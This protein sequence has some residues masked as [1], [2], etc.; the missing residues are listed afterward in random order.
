M[1][2]SNIFEKS[3]LTLKAKIMRGKAAQEDAVWTFRGLPSGEKK[4]PV[5]ISKTAT[6]VTCTVDIEEVPADKDSYMVTYELEADKRKYPGFYAYRVWP[7]SITLKSV[8]KDGKPFPNFPFRVKQGGILPPAKGKGPDTGDK[9]E[10][11]VELKLTGAATIEPLSPFEIDKWNKGDK[12][13]GRAREA[14][15]SRK[16]YTALFYSHPEKDWKQYVNMPPTP[17]PGSNSGSRMK[18][19]VGPKEDK[20]K[21]NGRVG[22][23]GDE[24]F[25]EV[26]FSDKNSKRNDPKPRLI[27][28]GSDVAAEAD[29]RTFKATLK[30]GEGGDPAEFQVEMGFAGGD[31]CTVKAGVTKACEDD[32]VKVTAWRKLLLEVIQPKEECSAYTMSFRTDKKPGLTDNH[33]SL[34]K[35]ELDPVFIE[36]DCSKGV[37]TY[38]KSDLGGKA[39]YLVFDG[40]Y[41]KRDAGKKMVILTNG[42]YGDLRAAKAT[43]NPQSPTSLVTA[44][45]DYYVD[46]AVVNVITELDGTSKTVEL[47]DPKCVFEFDPGKADGTL[48]V[49][50]F[51]WW[52]KQYKNQA[53]QWVNVA[54]PGDPGY[55]KRTAQVATITGADLDQWIHFTHFRKIIV[56]LPKRAGKEATDPGFFL[57]IGGRP[58]RIGVSIKFAGAEI[59][60]LAGGWHG[61]IN[62]STYGGSP[63]SGG[64]VST[65]LH[66]LGHNLGQAYGNQTTDPDYGRTAANAIPGMPFPPGV[67]A[68]VVYGA[69]GHNGTHCAT[70][71]SDANRAEPSFN[72]AAIAAQAKC[73]MFGSGDMNSDHMPSF[74]DQCRTYIRATEAHNLTK[75]WNA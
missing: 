55:D 33:V 7:G 2:E 43:R 18:F 47:D 68:G 51:A 53:G 17:R 65:L 67:A 46:E 9:G 3:K 1:P 14:Q 45:A 52:A 56:K 12:D 10:A 48:G 31:V 11:K 19:Q 50:R 21:A 60:A 6:E 29:G 26:A 8:G 35:K 27:V 61:W 25:I 41:F 23:K 36:M 5:K 32:K 28:A 16:P 69:K 4:V 13:K 37:A 64:L 74:C 63:K 66:E 22:T 40:T 24:I 49:V 20:G 15:V 73:I 72:T 59:T 71:L 58:V 30:L 70:G 62:M 34:I 54:N 42:Q 57:T 38:Q 75:V 44:W 39:P